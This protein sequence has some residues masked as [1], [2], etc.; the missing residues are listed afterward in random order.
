MKDEKVVDLPEPASTHPVT[1]AIARNALAFLARCDLKGN[2]VGALLDVH[3]ALQEVINAE[4][5]T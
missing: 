2:E 5:N 4:Q 1:P 3:N